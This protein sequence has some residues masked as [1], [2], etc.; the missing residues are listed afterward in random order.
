M[1]LWERDVA[2]GQ[3]AE[4]IRLGRFRRADSAQAFR[5]DCRL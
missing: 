5:G 1:L 4:L 3:Q 2:V